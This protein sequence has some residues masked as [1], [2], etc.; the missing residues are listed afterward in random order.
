[1]RATVAGRDR[2]LVRRARFRL[3]RRAVRRSLDA[4]R[5]FSRVVYRPRRS[6]SR[7]VTVRAAVRLRDGR[8][9]RLSRR[10]RVC[11]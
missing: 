6:R 10:V 8:L 1:M 11:R 9:V 5:P 2:A 4:R 3:G 7:R